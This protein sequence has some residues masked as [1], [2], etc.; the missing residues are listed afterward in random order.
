MEEAN[1]CPESS[2]QF[3]VVSVRTVGSISVEMQ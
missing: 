1:F 2:G 3:N